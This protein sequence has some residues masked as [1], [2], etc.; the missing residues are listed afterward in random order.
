MS[1]L[2]LPF[3]CWLFIIFLFLLECSSC[4]VGF[5][6]D[7]PFRA[8]E[9]G[10]HSLSMIWVPYPVCHKSVN[11]SFAEEIP[12]FWPC[13]QLSDIFLEVS[14]D[15]HSFLPIPLLC[16]ELE[17]KACV[18][19]LSDEDFFWTASPWP[20]YLPVALNRLRLRGQCHRPSSPTQASSDPVLVDAHSVLGSL[21]QKTIN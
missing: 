8:W 2:P 14:F 15:L 21:V 9:L 12:P 16:T 20:V 1:R 4:P 11:I 7:V 18:D 19:I 6:T 10:S 17:N 3:I 5:D 13:P